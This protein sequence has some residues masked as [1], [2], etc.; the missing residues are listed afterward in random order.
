ML[1][2]WITWVSMPWFVASASQKPIQEAYIQDVSTRSVDDLV[3]AMGM[4]GISKSQV[5]RLCEE[6]DDRVKAFLDVWR[7]LDLG[8]LCCNKASQTRARAA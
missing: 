2:G 3:K 5:N 7:P 1:E 6:I 4:S 8:Q